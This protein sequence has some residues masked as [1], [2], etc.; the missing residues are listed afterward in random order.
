MK[1]LFL[2]LPLIGFAFFASAE[3]SITA[4]LADNDTTATHPMD[5]DHSNGS[6]SSIQP[7]HIEPSAKLIAS[8]TVFVCPMHPNIVRHSE[9]TCPICG[10]TLVEKQVQASTTKYSSTTI[11]SSVQ[12]NMGIRLAQ[13]KQGKMWKYINTLGRVTYDE[14]AAYHLHPR[15][16][17]WIKTLNIRYEGQAVKKDDILYTVYSP[18]I[19]AAQKELLFAMNRSTQDNSRMVT[20]AEDR[21]ILLGVHPTTIRTIKRTQKSILDIPFH[22]PAS[23]VV[24]A[25][26]VNDGMYIQ[27]NTELFSIVDLSKVW[28]YADVY[29]DQISW[30]QQDD[31]AVLRLDSYPN[32]KWA[33][34]VDYIYPKINIE[35]NTATVRLIFSNKKGLLI[36]NMFGNIEIFGGPRDNVLMIPE[37]AVIP[38]H[39]GYR[40]VKQLDDKTFLPIDIEVG[41]R[42]QGF[43]EII[44]GLTEGDTVVTSGQFLID[45]E[46]QL[47]ASFSRLSTPAGEQAPTHTQHPH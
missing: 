43:I 3:P 34:K 17:G 25:L 20:S 21:L 44:D 30:F 23:G 41:M 39:N 13:A 7:S 19:V 27:P 4:S 18:E 45:S 33:G 37:E 28:V 10:M 22:A 15:T 9:G 38:F 36:P 29:V 16:T 40:V 6:P 42:R 47:N 8:S 31:A 12:Q 2:G 5:V 24:L 35:N 46:S 14:E 32:K 26:S 1:T 11:T